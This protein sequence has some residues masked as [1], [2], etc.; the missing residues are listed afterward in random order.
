M[1][2]TRYV[3]LGTKICW[4]MVKDITTT[5]LMDAFTRSEVLVMWQRYHLGTT[6][7]TNYL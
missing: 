3:M 2:R 7:S 1:K 6:A 4:D 5:E